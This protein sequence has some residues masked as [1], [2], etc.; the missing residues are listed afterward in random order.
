MRQVFSSPRTENV[1][2]VAQMLREA[3]IQVRVTHGRSY[4]GGLRGNFSYRDNAR[5]GPVPAVWVVLSEDQPRAREILRA[6]G[7]LDSTRS[8]TGYRLPAF[9]TEEPLA[10]D[11][12]GRKRAFRLKM[13]LLLVIAM[14]IG[15]A[16]FSRIGPPVPTTITAT[17]PVAS[18]LPAGVSPTPDALALAVLA[19]ELPTRADQALCLSVDGHDP[20]PALLAALPPTPGQVIALSQCPASDLPRLAIADYRVRAPSGA[21]SI[22]L[23]RAADAGAT[24]VVDSYEVNRGAKG[25]RVIELL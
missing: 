6:Q 11:D 18:A 16:F 21:G 22:S 9:R 13:G 7:L 17:K 4:R 8:D 1:E 3:G 12:P 25:W 2:G 24:P 14:V 5:E 20:S 19:G 15:L 23:S 10:A